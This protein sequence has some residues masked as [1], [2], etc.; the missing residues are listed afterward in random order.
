[1]VKT[2]F[3]D[4]IN[5]NLNKIVG[6]VDYM[7]A[8][9]VFLIL[10][11][12]FKD[13]LM[14][15]FTNLCVFLLTAIILQLAMKDVLISILGAFLITSFYNI[16]QIDN[17]ENFKN[18]DKKLKALVEKLEKTKSDI[19]TATKEDFDD[20]MSDEYYDNDA[21]EGKDVMKNS[22]VENLTASQAQRE[23]FKLIDTGK[24]LQKHMEQMVP[25]LKKANSMMKMI[26][27]MKNV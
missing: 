26:K 1:M 8:V 24:T 9:I 18:E 6:N 23:L 10:L 25:G 12:V 14:R 17:L 3:I 7:V 16:S 27:S 5:S 19:D 20:I 13:K 11:I 22:K 4:N 2:N 15:Q 21:K